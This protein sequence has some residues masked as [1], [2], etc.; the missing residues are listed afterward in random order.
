MIRWWRK[1]SNTGLN[2]SSKVGPTLVCP[3]EQ[4][5]SQAQTQRAGLIISISDPEL[6]TRTTA[7]LRGYTGAVC[8]LD[9]HDIERPAPGL[10]MADHS[11]IQQAVDSARAMK[12]SHALVVHCHAG[13]SR[14][15]AMALLATIARLQVQGLHDQDAVDGAFARVAQSAPHMRPNMGI[16]TLGEDLLKL[17]DTDLVE[18]A[19]RRHR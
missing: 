7:Q 11:H 2:E 5:R 8:A 3:V 10:V 13:V 4:A 17:Q 15:S 18:R 19:W 14:S 9:F 12:P 16:I 1:T 6:R